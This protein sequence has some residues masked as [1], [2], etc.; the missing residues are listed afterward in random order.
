MTTHKDLLVWQ[1]SIE[2]TVSVYKISKSFPNDKSLF[3]QIQRAAISI[4]SNISEGCAR[5][6]IK[7]YLRFL[8]IS[9]ASATEVDTQLIIANKLEL[10]NLEEFEELRDKI[11]SILKL[12]Q[13]LINSLK[14]KLP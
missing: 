2:F 8:Y 1:K 14:K 3:N 5:N 6:S 7:E 13:L 11:T 9:R 4:P 10:I 12:L